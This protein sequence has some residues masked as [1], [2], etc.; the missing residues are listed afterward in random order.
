MGNNI[1]IGI[2]NSLAYFKHI[3]NLNLDLS[4]LKI[5]IDNSGEIFEN[6]HVLEQV[7][8][9]KLKLKFNE[10]KEQGAI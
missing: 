1:G 5:N 3:H 9:F 2:S 7:K 4:G 6:F 10:I 8:T